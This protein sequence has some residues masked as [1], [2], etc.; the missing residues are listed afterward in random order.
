MANRSFKIVTTVLTIWTHSV[1]EQIRTAAKQAE[2]LDYN[3]W[4]KTQ[5][6]LVAEPAAASIATSTDAKIESNSI[7]K[8]RDN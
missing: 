5:T 8:V 4:G 1:N 7:M 2:M 3:P 6:R